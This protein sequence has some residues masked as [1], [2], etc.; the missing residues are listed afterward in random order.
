MQEKDDIIVQ[1]DR[2]LAFA[3]AVSDFLVE[4]DSESRIAFSFGA[5]KRLTGLD[6]AGVKG[7]LWTDFFPDKD[8]PILKSMVSNASAGRRCGPVFVTMQTSDK[9]KSESVLFSAIKMPGKDS[10]Y[11]TLAFPNA[12]M[13]R[14]GAEQRK[15]EENNILFSQEDFIKSAQL[16]M[17]AAAESG[18]KADM[19]LL[20]MPELQSMKSRLSEPVWDQVTDL[21]ANV[22]KS[23]SIDGQTVTRISEGRY[24]VLHDKN[25]TSQLIQEQIFNLLKENDPE[26]KGIAVNSSSVDAGTET[27]NEKE[28]TRALVYTLKEFEK[29]GARMEVG[30]LEDGFKGFL[31][32]SAK[33]IQEFKTIIAKHDFHLFFQPIVSL[34]NLEIGH[35]EMLT[36]FKE[37]TS[38]YEWI[39]FG[40]DVGLATSFDI[41]VCER[42]IAYV[43]KMA[44]HTKNKFAVNIS[45]QSIE[46]DQFM[47]DLRALLDKNKNLAHFLMFEI[48]ES[49]GITELDK[50]N[51]F[52]GSLQ[53]D[54]F[55][56]CLDDFGAGSASFQYLHKL[57]VDYVKL[58]GA[59]VQSIFENKRNETMVQ[60]LAQLCK[61]LNIKM[62]AERIE[63][64]QEALLLRKMG[65]EY[66]QGYWFSKP[67]PG[68][69]YKPSKEKLA[70]LG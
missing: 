70:L 9:Q 44:L 60:N 40:E 17:K 37:G 25:I 47:A 66:G 33:K 32:E 2:F 13:S 30:K 24:G 27:L 57:H 52:I 28:I 18:Q 36:R 46:N 58:D 55:K 4:I 38:P 29:K 19:T 5:V 67:T 1:R 23:R 16:A 48:T 42:A 26:G 62:V 34:S 21:M 50:V 54:G 6:T 22:L 69:Q 39:T 15:Q 14:L 65:T 49:A 7:R 59:Y 63:T 41:A 35:Y 10:T 12:M 8:K 20:D 64:E 56:I 3:F 61:S 31:N 53:K 51:N 11:I 43:L 45:G 68:P